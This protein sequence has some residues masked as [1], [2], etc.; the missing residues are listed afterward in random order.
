MLSNPDAAMPKGEPGPMPTMTESTVL[1]LSAV[2]FHRIAYTEWGAGP[3]T[4][5]C[6]HGLTRNGRDF[7]VLAADLAERLDA[8]V[9]CPDVV[10]RGRSDRLADPDLYGYPQYLADMTALIARLDVKT[11][12]W[13]GTSMGG[14][15]GMMLAAQRNSPIRRLVVNDVGPFI[16]KAALERIGAY[17]GVDHAFDGMAALEGYLRSTYAGFGPLTDGQWRHLAT[18][19]AQPLAD[20]RLALAY[21]TGIARIFA[22]TPVSDVDLWPL[23]GRITAPTLVIRGGLSD[24]LSA[25]T[26]ERMTREGPKAEL[27]TFPGV[28]HAPALMDADQ[29][30][31]VRTFLGR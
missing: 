23:W 14:L 9:I 17:V 12:D 20:G 16:P 4:I 1:G 21:D 18:H 19:S 22:R 10:G 13:V 3:R 30:D 5:V 11:V 24:L 15:I 25:E 27:A 29:V 2:G 7:D 28:G 6:V 26:A 31:L 8:R